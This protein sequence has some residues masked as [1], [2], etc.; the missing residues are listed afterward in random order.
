MQDS[1]DPKAADQG[2]DDHVSD[3]SAD[4]SIMQNIRNAIERLEKT[5]E[6][7]TNLVVTWKLLQSI[8]L[9]LKDKVS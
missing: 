5:S 4:M 8:L 9:Q 3:V 1:T 2:E 6:G 7:F